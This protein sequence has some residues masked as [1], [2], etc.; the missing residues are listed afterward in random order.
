MEDWLTT[1]H[2][3][4]THPD[5]FPAASPAAA[6]AASRATPAPYLAAPAAALAA[7]P[8]APV[9]SPAAPVA[10]PIALATSPAAPAPSPAAPATSP[11]VCSG[12]RML[13]GHIDDDDA[14][15]VVDFHV[16]T[17]ST[18]LVLDGMEVSS[19]VVL[20]YKNSS[21]EHCPSL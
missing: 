1:S 14:P 6:T 11:A 19:I 8:A 13:R 3:V 2:K 21:T 20:V 16:S 4:D 5:N 18:L 15:S 10:F 17:L 7:F 9:A 12:R